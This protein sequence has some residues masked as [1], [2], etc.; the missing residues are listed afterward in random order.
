[1]SIICVT[2]LL[3]TLF[4][5]YSFICLFSSNKGLL[6]LA[7]DDIDDD[8]DETSSINSSSFGGISRRRSLGGR[9]RSSFGSH[10]SKSPASSADQTRIAEMYKNVIKMSSENVRFY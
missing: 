2:F 7:V 10:N 8:D 1:M 6:G 4:S 9:R 3:F 5:I